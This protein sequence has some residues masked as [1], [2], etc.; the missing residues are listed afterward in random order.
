MELGVGWSIRI[1]YRPFRIC[2][3]ECCRTGG[4]LHIDA[5]GAGGWW[6]ACGLSFYLMSPV[7]EDECARL[8]MEA[9]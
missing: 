5:A 2:V 3:E 7:H 6:S 4:A 9:A 1:D 8:G